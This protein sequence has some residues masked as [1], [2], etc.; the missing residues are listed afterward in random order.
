MLS[1]MQ[2]LPYPLIFRRVAT[3][4]AVVTLTLTLL[5]AFTGVLLAFY[6]E[7]AAGRAFNSLRS[8]ATEVPNGELILSVHNITG[9][10]LIGVALFEIIFMFLGRR[11]NRSWFT[12][13]VSGLLLL[14]TGI[15]LG[16]TAMILSWNQLGYWRFRIE[17]G[18]IEAIPVIGNTLRDI[19]TGGG[20]V[21]TTTVEHLYTIHSYIL[22]IGAV[23]LAIVHL[24]ALVKASRQ[25]T[26]PTLPEVPL[27]ESGALNS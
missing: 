17:L 11:F 12:S 6:Y 18:T 10:G 15:A 14:L 16:W 22:S 9:N 24:A 3:I 21:N 19:L 13:W 25:A 5:A 8:I 20:S 7:P 1:A 23:V 27:Q 2:T 26:E 4:L